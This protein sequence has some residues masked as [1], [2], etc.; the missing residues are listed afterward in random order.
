MLLLLNVGHLIW[1]ILYMPKRVYMLVACGENV[2]CL[3]CLLNLWFKV[4][5]ILKVIIVICA[6]GLNDKIFRNLII[7]SPALILPK[8]KGLLSSFNVLYYT[9]IY[10]IYSFFV[11]ASQIYS[12]ISS[13]KRFYNQYITN[14]LPEHTIQHNFRAILNEHRKRTA[15][16]APQ[17]TPQNFC[18]KNTKTWFVLQRE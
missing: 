13:F 4:S 15:S 2:M 5:T 7:I 11:Q 12:L 8:D 1:I 14:T 3:W 9:Y 17:R 6:I 16:R 10:N 18:V